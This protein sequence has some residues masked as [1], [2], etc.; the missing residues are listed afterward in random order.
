MSTIHKP[1]HDDGALKNARHEA[2]VQ[3]IA[4]GH[5][6]R[7]AYMAAYPKTK[8]PEAADAS[9][10]RL[11]GNASVAAR[12][13]ELQDMVRQHAAEE[14]GVD[15]DWLLKQGKEVLR[16]AL[17][18]KAFNAASMTIERLAK[19][20]GNWV[21]QSDNEHDHVHRVYSSAPLTAEEWAKQYPQAAPPKAS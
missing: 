5:T 19:I 7:D 16:Q 11:L 17:A 6:H 14:H 10:A 8:T 1:Q 21:D 12:L 20:S 3:A 13:A 18:N 4:H 15:L 2:V 9:V